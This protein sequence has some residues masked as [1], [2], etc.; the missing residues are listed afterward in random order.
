MGKADGQDDGN[1]LRNRAPSE[2][3]FLRDSDEEERNDITGPV[4]NGGSTQ[5]GQGGDEHARGLHLR[6]ATITTSSAA[7]ASTSMATVTHLPRSSTTIPDKPRSVQTVL[8]AHGAVWNLRSDGNAAAH[9]MRKRKRARLPSEGDRVQIRRSSFRS[10]LSQLLGGGRNALQ[11]GAE[12]EES[13]RVME[14]AR[15]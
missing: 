5:F 7:S 1:R 9:G 11:D 13:E 2:S 10:S 12:V 6:N 4:D 15:H 14:I 3:L 8:S